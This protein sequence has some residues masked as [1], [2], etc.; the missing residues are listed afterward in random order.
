LLDTPPPEPLTIDQLELRPRE[1]QALVDGRRV[2]LTIREFQV[3]EALCRRRDRVVA[4]HELYGAVWGGPMAARDRSVDVFVRKVRLKL[5]TV[6]PEWAYIHTHHGVGYRFTPERLH[7]D[8]DGD[9]R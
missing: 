5:A 1:Y 9:G 3:L 8:A 4:R 2:G 6:S 7:A